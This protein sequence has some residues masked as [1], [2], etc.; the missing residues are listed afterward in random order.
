MSWERALELAVSCPFR[1][2]I[3]SISLQQNPV[4]THLLDD[5]PDVLGI[6]AGDKSCDSDLAARVSSDPGASSLDVTSE[7]VS[8][9]W[10]ICRNPNSIQDPETIRLCI[11]DVKNKGKIILHGQVELSGEH[12]HLDR[13]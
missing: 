12:L 2:M 11:A 3:G 10:V 1:Q 4:K 6:M 5:S 7:A 9:D 13:P 8:V